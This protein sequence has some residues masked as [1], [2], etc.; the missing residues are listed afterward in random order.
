MPVF[1]SQTCL[2]VHTG[3]HVLC[4]VCLCICV[5]GAYVY[6]C[7]HV[8]VIYAYVCVL[9]GTIKPLA[10]PAQRAL[11][12]SLRLCIAGLGAGSVSVSLSL[13][14]CLYWGHT[15]RGGGHSLAWCPPG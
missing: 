11:P 5:W 1:L 10:G 6:I 12:M 3:V 9:W 4:C 14:A 15:L 8:Y 7:L 13:H 2:R